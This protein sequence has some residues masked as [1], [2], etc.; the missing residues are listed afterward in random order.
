MQDGF[1]ILLL[2]IENNIVEYLFIL[3]ISICIYYFL[4]IRKYIWDIFDPLL[5]M[6]I[7]AIFAS[8]VPIY[9]YIEDLLDKEYFFFSYIITELAF[10]LGF[11]I[12]G[13]SNSKI[14]INSVD[15]VTER[16]KDIL[17]K[18]YVSIYFVLIIYFYLKI[19]IP[20][21]DFDSH[22][23]AATKS[24]SMTIVLD[25]ILSVLVFLYIERLFRRKINLS[26]IL[27]GIMIVSTLLLSGS[28]S[29]FLLIAQNLFFYQL[30]LRKFNKFE[31]YSFKKLYVYIFF[32]A[33]IVAFIPIIASLE[34]IDDWSIIIL[35]LLV[36]LVG[37][38]DIFA[39]FYGSGI[40][41]IILNNNSFYNIVI[42]SVG[43]SFRL[44]DHVEAIGFQIMKEISNSNYVPTGPNTRHNILAIVLFGLYMGPLYS[45]FIGALVFFI[46]RW[47]YKNIIGF[48]FFTFIIYINI[49]SKIIALPTEFM[50]VLQGIIVNVLLNGIIMYVV[51]ISLYKGEKNR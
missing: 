50:G 14:K 25:S 34:Y 43:A 22:V 31:K 26:I 7:G 45:F 10:L 23:E 27:V 37:Y 16:M 12:F 20:L 35:N 4:I 5:L 40:S 36:R 6:F 1:I 28:K 51:W 44:S 32:I 48:N 33:I 30:Y 3:C 38:G 13:L 24:V 47:C 29:S 49:Y 18:I 2:S 8:T 11:K 9:M 41:D 39:Y 19:G 46:S 42:E 17:Y 21:L 15:L